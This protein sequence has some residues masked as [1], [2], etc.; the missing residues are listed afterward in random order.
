MREIRN[1]NVDDL[2]IDLYNG[3]MLNI[4]VPMGRPCTTFYLFTIA[5]FA[6]SVTVCGI[7]TFELH[8]VLDS[9]ILHLI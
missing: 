8:N 6:L 3:S 1:R 4:N 7:I 9:N 2:D 5:M